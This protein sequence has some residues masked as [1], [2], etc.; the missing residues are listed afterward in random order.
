MANVSQ[1]RSSTK[2]L[3]QQGIQSHKHLRR[4]WLIIISRQDK[5]TTNSCSTTKKKKHS[6]GRVHSRRTWELKDTNTGYDLEWRSITS[7]CLSVCLSVCMSF[8][9][10]FDC[11]FKAIRFEHIADFKQEKTIHFIDATFHLTSE[12]CKPFMKPNTKLLYVQP[13]STHPPAKL[14]NI[15]ENIKNDCL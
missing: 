10:C 9:V 3:S 5:T 6:H 14:K 13:Q 7:V 11:Y 2:P 8:L 4:L 1:I 15:P 12:T